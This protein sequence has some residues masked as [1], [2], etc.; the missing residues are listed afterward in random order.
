VLQNIEEA[1]KKRPYSLQNLVLAQKTA[2]L[3][4]KC[5]DDALKK[6]LSCPPGEYDCTRKV[7]SLSFR[8]NEGGTQEQNAF[9]PQISR[10]APSNLPPIPPEIS[11]VTLKK[12][13][14][15]SSRRVYS[16]VK[17]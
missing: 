12:L 16:A 15:L 8:R 11:R 7:A 3:S 13:P 2:S 1:R 14:T 9:P 10:V 17:K 6:L 4:Y 5:I